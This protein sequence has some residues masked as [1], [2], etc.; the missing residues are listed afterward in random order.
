[1]HIHILGICGTFM[2]GIALLARE[3]GHAVSGS[4]QNVYPPMSTQLEQSGIALCHG[5]S[6]NDLKPAP[7]LVIIGNT[8]SRGNACIEYILDAGLP[9]TSG[10]QWLS[11][12]ILRHKHVLAVSGTH[13]KTTTTSMLAWLLEQAG[14]HCGFLVGGVAENFGVSARS[15]LS[16]HF[17]IEADEYDTAFFDKRS[18]FI[19]YHASTL[20]INNIEFDHADIFA[21]ISDI[22]RQ[23]HHLL[24]TVPA[25]GQIVARHGDVEI[26]KVLTM[27]CWTPVQT[28]GL[29]TGDWTGKPGNS[30]YSNFRVFYGG[31][32]IGQVNWQLI[33]AHNAEN[34]LAAIAAAARVGVDPGH[35]CTSL[36]GF[37]SVKR[38]LQLLANIKGVSVY[39]DFAHH[40]T[41]IRA[42]LDALRSRV[43]TDRIIAVLEPRSNTMKMGTHKETLAASLDGADQ[44]VLY[45]GPDVKW[46][47][48]TISTKLGD[49]CR[50]YENIEDI[51]GRITTISQVG[52]HIVI[53]SNGGFENI[54]QRLIKRLQSAYG[55]SD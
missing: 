55:T 16:D 3:L 27:G 40:P 41:A 46:D 5:Y 49:K 15:G 26:S 22:R 17:V 34:A 2:G 30:D 6:V 18:K 21:D 1:M 11:E 12:N 51:I 10:P 4:D 14:N 39:D 31:Q 32:E 52:V 50:I 33:G 9:F 53:M 44:V 38:R 47:L 48:S 23:F 28:F 19:H 25:S 7:D 35:A 37:R 24:K 8:L 43:G 20:I 13:G 36:T 29:R 42:T 54:H 45:Q